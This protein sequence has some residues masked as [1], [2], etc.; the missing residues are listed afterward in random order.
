MNQPDS[1]LGGRV[2]PHAVVRRNPLV[3]SQRIAGEKAAVLLHLDTSAY[4]SLN[5]VG[6]LIWDL[7]EQPMAV[8]RL[9]DLLAA[10][11]SD[12]PPWLEADLREFLQQ[13]ADRTLVEVE[14]IPGGRT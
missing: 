7:M 10:R 8:E 12:A 13:L 9:T 5:E 3:V 1:G 6:A 14:P 4:H 2:E 11:F